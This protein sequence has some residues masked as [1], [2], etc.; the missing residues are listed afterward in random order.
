MSGEL[1]EKL[2]KI[3]FSRYESKVYSTLTKICNAKMRELAELSGVP[4]QKVYDVV[5]RL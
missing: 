1:E 2:I 3:G 4:Y 5:S